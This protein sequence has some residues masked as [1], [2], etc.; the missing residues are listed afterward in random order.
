M[1]FEPAADYSAAFAAMPREHPRR[2]TLELFEEAI[3]VP[4]TKWAC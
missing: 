3:C 2:R 1:I 4:G